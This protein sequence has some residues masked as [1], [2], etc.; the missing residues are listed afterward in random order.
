L[1]VEVG[2]RWEGWRIEKGERVVNAG[3]GGGLGSEGR[4]D[5]GEGG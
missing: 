1:G 3:W 4:G 5:G 2:E